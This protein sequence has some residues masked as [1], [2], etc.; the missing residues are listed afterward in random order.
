M[1]IISLKKNEIDSW[2]YFYFAHREDEK[3]YLLEVE[4][5]EKWVIFFEEAPIWFDRE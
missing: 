4:L 3:E 1:L 5:V 2:S